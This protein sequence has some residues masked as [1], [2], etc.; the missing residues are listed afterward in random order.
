MKTLKAKYESTCAGCGGTIH[1][2]QTITG[3]GG[4]WYHGP[5]GGSGCAPSGNPGADAAYLQGAREANQYLEYLED[6]RFYGEEIADAL[7]LD[8]ELNDPEGW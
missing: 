5:G 1:K 8:R 6:R 7:E 3:S 2:G 4:D